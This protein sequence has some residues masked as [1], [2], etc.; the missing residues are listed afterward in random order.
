MIYD[1][2]LHIGATPEAIQFFIKIKDAFNQKN[3]TVQLFTVNTE[4][5]DFVDEKH[6]KDIIVLPKI[7]EQ[8]NIE[9]SIQFVKSLGFFNY[10]SLYRTQKIFHD[11]SDKDGQILTAKKIEAVKGI[12]H[13][14]KAKKYMTFAG[15]EID[16]NMFRVYA[17]AQGGKI[18]F[19]GIT[20]LNNRVFITDSEERFFNIPKEIESIPESEKDWIEKYIHNII[21]KRPILWADPK[22]RDVH[23]KGIWILKLIK[24]IS[25]KSDSTKT[26]KFIIQRFIS[27]VK[28]RFLSKN[29]YCNTSVLDE[30]PFFYMPM[31]YPKDSQLT[32][33]GLPFLNQADIIDIVSRFIPTEYN[34]IIKE[35]PHARGF[36][37]V[38]DIK[39]ISQLDRT[40]IIHPFVNS[41][42]IMKKA[43]AIIVINS[44][45]GFEALLYNKAVITLG[46][47]FFRGH[48]L[49]LDVNSLYDIE[50]AIEQAE[51]F[52]PN[53]QKLEQFI[54]KIKKY[55]LD[56]NYTDLFN[57]NE[58]VINTYV[59]EII[60]KLEF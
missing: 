24:R 53:R 6:L 39:R 47:S 42:E 38:K 55:S 29:H 45:V 16:L 58:E 26:T 23:F 40:K 15:D 31:H 37:K 49:T 32:L 52:Q 50:A 36:S 54:Y 17:K 35:H 43:N 10:S 59:E 12:L 19:S 51:T 5:S 60:N 13:L 48:G 20:N 30:K 28:N 8:Y 22:E 41:H 7:K 46:K 56:V 9:E 25:Y 57:S 1:L 44:S 14:P 4:V 21:E 11:L 3:I 2:C 34:L 18:Y 27:R 33:R